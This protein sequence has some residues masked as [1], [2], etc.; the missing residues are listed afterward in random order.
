MWRSERQRNDTILA[1]LKTARLYTP[2]H[3]TF[4]RGLWTEDGPTDLACDYIEKGC[5]LSHGETL[6]LQVAFD[7]WNG[8]GGAKVGELLSTLDEPNLRGVCDAI[9]ARDA[10]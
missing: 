5:P 7:I 6:V 4:D 1:L 3:P 8:A 10:R 2:E 9:L